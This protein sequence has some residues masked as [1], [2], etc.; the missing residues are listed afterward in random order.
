MFVS[1]FSEHMNIYVEDKYAYTYKWTYASPRLAPPFPHCI[2]LLIFVR[3]KSWS[4][5]AGVKLKEN[6]LTGH[7]FSNFLNSVFLWGVT[8]FHAKEEV[9]T[10]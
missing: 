7:K 8:M 10:F 9:L 1:N 4:K 3:K 6:F 5:V 2:L